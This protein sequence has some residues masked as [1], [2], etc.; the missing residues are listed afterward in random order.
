MLAAYCRYLLCRPF[1]RVSEE[2]WA[3]S[4]CPCTGSR[5]IR[6]SESSGDRD[7][8]RDGPASRMRQ[9]GLRPRPPWALADNSCCRSSIDLSP[10]HSARCPFDDFAE[11]RYRFGERADAMAHV[12]AFDIPIRIDEAELQT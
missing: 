10:A 2:Q 6:R 9:I 5:E 8:R 4:G 11:H 1:C 12:F 3:V 7:V